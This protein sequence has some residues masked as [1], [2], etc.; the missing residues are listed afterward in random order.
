M[1]KHLSGAHPVQLLDAGSVF[2]GGGAAAVQQQRG[3]AVLG[4]CYPV[5]IQST[6]DKQGERTERNTEMQARC[7]LP[8]PSSN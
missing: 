2:A 6:Q 7:P 1:P 4:K 5:Q 8:H 3:I